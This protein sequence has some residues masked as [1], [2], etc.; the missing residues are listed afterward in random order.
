[1]LEFTETIKFCIPKGYLQSATLALF[2]RAGYDILNY[3]KDAKC[4]RASIRGH[5]DIVLKIVKPQE[6]PYLVEI[7]KYDLGITGLD[8]IRE[9]EYSPIGLK[10]VRELLDLKYGKVDVI[11]AI[12]NDWNNISSLEDLLTM[13]R[14]VTIATE[15]VNIARKIIYER[16]NE[17][18][19]II[20][21]WFIVRNSKCINILHTFG[22]TEGKPPEDADAIIDITATGRTL[23]ENKLKIIERYF[24]S[25]ARLVVNRESLKNP[26][27]KQKI[28][29]LV[30]SFKSAVM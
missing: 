11:L 16:I 12:P 2:K 27:K 1:M 17:E 24:T 6:V 7:G 29:E 9:W 25:T 26:L 21:P 3:S 19:S 8:W 22:A 18:P 5:D 30:S 23:R 15:F 14:E 13:K 4:Y 20:S 10:N 28:H